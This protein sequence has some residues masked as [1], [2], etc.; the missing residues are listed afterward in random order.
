M[1]GVTHTVINKS[2]ARAAWSPS[3][4]ADIGQSQIRT[5]FFSKSPVPHFVSL[6]PPPAGRKAYVEHPY[7][8]F[9]LPSEKLIGRVVKG[10]VRDS[11]SFAVEAVLE[12][13]EREWSNKIGVR[14][15]V[16]EVLNRR[17]KREEDGT[18]SWIGK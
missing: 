16:E 1:T 17:T 6:N 12:W 2:K 15:K 4:L 14:E 7:A 18:L 10:D 9:A 11:G 8:A 3:T 13:F 5:T